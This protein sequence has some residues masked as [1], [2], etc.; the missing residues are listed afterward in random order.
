MKSHNRRAFALSVIAL[1][2]AFLF[3][4]VS[5]ASTVTIDFNGIDASSGTVSGT[6]VTD[7]LA[8][9][10]VTTSTNQVYV[11]SSVLN[12][13]IA[14]PTTNVFSGGDFTGTVQTLILDFAN[15]VNDFS[16]VRAGFWGA[17]STSGNTKG[18]WTA[19]AY[20]ASHTALASVGEGAV[21][22]YGDEPY[23]TFSLLANNIS[24]VT[25]VGN[26]HGFYG[27][28]VPSITNISY[29]STVPVP[30][31][32][33]LFGSGLLGLISMARRKAT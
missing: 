26:H 27:G 9:F 17:Y 28:A 25:F 11:F 20:D 7:Y 15:P 33:W 23:L 1:G 8:G 13:F 16:F 3:A 2:A 22:S 6:P 4:E 12:N 32:V 19:T 24:Y 21:A 14:S 29:T 30:T 5:H 31:A 10:G 18:D